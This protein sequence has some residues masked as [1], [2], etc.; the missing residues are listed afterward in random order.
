MPFSCLVP[1]A[2]L[3]NYVYSLGGQS[4]VGR[5]GLAERL[6]GLAGVSE[7]VVVEEDGVAYLRI[8]RR[9]FDESTLP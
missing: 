1:P 9:V 6:R 5:E 8:D 4:S 3:S 7:A 2:K